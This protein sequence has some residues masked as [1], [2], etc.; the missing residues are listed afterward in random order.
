MPARHFPPGLDCS[1]FP[2]PVGVTG[3]A[4]GYDYRSVPPVAEMPLEA[5]CAGCMFLWSGWDLGPL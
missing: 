5:D 1:W 3:L 4:P 2:C